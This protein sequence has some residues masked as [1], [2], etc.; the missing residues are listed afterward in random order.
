V[1]LL[2]VPELKSVK[3]IPYSRR[4]LRDLCKAGKFPKPVPISEARIGF[5]ESEVDA[6]LEAKAAARDMPSPKPNLEPSLGR[7]K[8]IPIACGKRRR[9]PRARPADDPPA[10]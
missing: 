9:L 8:T 6:W 5:V 7:P 1:R 10:P 3:G 2:T 4:H